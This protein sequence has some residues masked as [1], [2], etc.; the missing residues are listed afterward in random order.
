MEVD[1]FGFIGNTQANAVQL[2]DNAVMRDDLADHGRKTQ[3]QVLGCGADE[4]NEGTEAAG[5]QAVCD[6][7]QQIEEWLQLGS[8]ATPN[9]WAILAAS[10]ASMR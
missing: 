10:I 3:D 4:V 6:H 9:E 5:Y 1:V 2:F 8:W 7:N